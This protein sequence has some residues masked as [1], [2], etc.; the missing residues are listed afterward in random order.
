MKF[1]YW[2]VLLD[3]QEIMNCV[4]KNFLSEQLLRIEVGNFL[5]KFQN[6]VLLGNLEILWTHLMCVMLFSVACINWQIVEFDQNANAFLLK[7]LSPNI[8]Q[9]HSHTMCHRHVSLRNQVQVTQKTLKFHYWDVNLSSST[10][11]L[12][13]EFFQNIHN[14]FFLFITGKK[15]PQ[16]CCSLTVKSCTFGS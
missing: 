10:G 3:I 5:E 11:I 7:I 2:F 15:Q 8:S 12:N 1:L 6:S 14:F 13:H 16:I 9:V 4:Q